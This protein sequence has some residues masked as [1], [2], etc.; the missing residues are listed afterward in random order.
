MNVY[1][2]IHLDLSA[3]ALGECKTNYR[4][5]ANTIS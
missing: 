5:Y 4:V 1:K 2:C 3:V